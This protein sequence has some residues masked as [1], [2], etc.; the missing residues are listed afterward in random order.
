M[1]KNKMMRLASAMMVLTLMSTSVISGT[2]AKYVTTASGTDSARVAKWG[3][4]VTSTSDMFNST[5]KIDDTTVTGITNSVNAETVEGKQDKLVAPGTTK[6]DVAFTISGTPEVAVNVSVKIDEKDK[7]AGVKDVF[8]KAGTYT[9]YTKVTG[10]DTDGNATYGTFNLSQDYYPLNW[11]LK[12]GDN[13]VATGTLSDIEKYLENSTGT[14]LSGNYAPNTDLSKLGVD[15]AS[16]QY[17]LSW[18]WA[19]ERTDDVQT[20]DIDENAL[21]NAADTLLGNL[22]AKKATIDTDK[23]C[24][25]VAYELSITVTQID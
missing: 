18:T 7:D 15:D 16:G 24:L 9:D 4:V 6:S 25:D 19:F 1:K 10:Y 20:T 11:S 3:V 17:T 2:F 22:A 12:N 5:Y 8:L 14:G 13:E 23:Y 21:Y